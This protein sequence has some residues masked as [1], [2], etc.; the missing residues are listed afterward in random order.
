VL[1]ITVAFG[2]LSAMRAMTEHEVPVVQRQIKQEYFSPGRGVFQV[3]QDSATDPFAFAVAISSHTGYKKTLVEPAAIVPD[4]VEGSSE[5]ANDAGKEAAEEETM[6]TF[7]MRYLIQGDE[8]KDDGKGFDISFKKC[9][10]ADW[11]Q[12]HLKDSAVSS[13]RQ[14]DLIESHIEHDTFWCPNAFDLSFWGMKGDLDSK[15]LTMDFVTDSAAKLDGKSLLLLINNKKV[16]YEG[17]TNEQT[18]SI[19]PFTGIHWL[20]LSAENPQL[21]TVTYMRER[22]YK[23]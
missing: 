21:T 12:F 1:V 14:L 15:T 10:D 18:V 8:E 7:S 17:E 13:Q 22:I 20:P 9:T 16:A 4:D 5:D 11:E 3:R 19:K 23:A 2:Y 6:G